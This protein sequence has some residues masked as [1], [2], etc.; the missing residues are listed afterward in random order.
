MDRPNSTR[1]SLYRGS[2]ERFDVQSGSEGW[3]Q[4]TERFEIFTDAN[5]VPEADHRMLLLNHCGPKAYRLMR[6]AV[7]PDKPSTKSF[8]ELVQAAKDKFDPIPGVNAA[9]AAFY[10]RTQQPGESVATFMTELRR[11]A[12]RCQF[13]ATSTV[14]ERVDSQLNDSETGM[15]DSETWRRVLRGPKLSLKELYRTALLGETVLAQ[16]KL[17]DTQAAT[18]LEPRVHGVS[19]KR[20][21]KKE[22]QAAS[23]TQADRCWRCEVKGHTSDSCRF[24]DLFCYRCRKK[25]RFQCKKGHARKACRSNLPSRA[26]NR[27]S[28]CQGIPGILPV[29]EEFTLSIKRRLGERS[30]AQNQTG[31]SQRVWL[32]SVHSRYI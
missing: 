32:E 3:E 5:Q 29:K 12:A 14:S 11:L 13:E 28:G 24:K 17:L 18:A 1:M 21:G 15:A 30:R 7:A 31:T 9:R 2:L 8:T 6:E 19:S 26:P 27:Q 20:P 22:H 16:S 25:F 4:W 23:M 10:V